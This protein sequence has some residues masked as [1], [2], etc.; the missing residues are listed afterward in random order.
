LWLGLASWD[1]SKEMDRNAEK[2]C[3]EILGLLS[4]KLAAIGLNQG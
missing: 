2:F 1:I 4:G 3:P